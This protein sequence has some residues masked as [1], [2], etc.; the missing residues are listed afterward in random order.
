MIV[1]SSCTDKIPT[2]PLHEHS[3]T[4]GLSFYKND[5]LYL[6]ILNGKITSSNDK[7]T[8][9]SGD[10]IIFKLEMLDELGDKINENELDDDKYLN[11]E[12]SDTSVAKI[13]F[14][15]KLE[16]KLLTINAG[17][18]EVEFQVKHV[19]HIDFRTPKIQIHIK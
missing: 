7:F 1:F 13:E 18:T 15:N 3:E 8:F 16:V 6:Q 14:I 2:E 4:A 19:D 5:S 10:E 9:D 12:I 11:A 17:L